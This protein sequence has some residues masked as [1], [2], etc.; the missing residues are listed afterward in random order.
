VGRCIVGWKDAWVSD[1]V[2]DFVTPPRSIS[3]LLTV[4]RK[5]NTVIKVLQ[6]DKTTHTT[7]G[8]KFNQN[9]TQHNSVSYIIV[10]R[11][12]RLFKNHVKISL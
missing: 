9:I 1:W 6:S 3:V 2:S 12:V 11:A 10:T 8:A 5:Y 7:N 4:N